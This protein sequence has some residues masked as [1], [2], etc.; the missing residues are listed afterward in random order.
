MLEA[1]DLAGS[2]RDATGLAGCSRHRVAV[3]VAAR[4]GASPHTWSAAPPSSS[5]LT[6]PAADVSP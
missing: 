1:Y 5:T 4:A 6:A 3:Y 2:L